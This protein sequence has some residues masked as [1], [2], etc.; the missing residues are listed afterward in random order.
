M[1]SRLSAAGPPREPRHYEITPGWESA[2]LTNP[3]EDIKVPDGLAQA[4]HTYRVR[5]RMKDVTGRWSHWSAPVEFVAG[6]S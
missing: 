3:A 2:E 5:V 1:E 6:K 4:G